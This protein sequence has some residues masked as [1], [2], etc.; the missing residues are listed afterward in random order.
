MRLQQDL[1]VR[2]QEVKADQEQLKKTIAFTSEPEKSN[3][4]ASAKAE[5]DR[6]NAVIAASIN[7]C[8]SASGSA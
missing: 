4:I 2:A 6:A 3:L 1:A 5:Q 7:E 8:C